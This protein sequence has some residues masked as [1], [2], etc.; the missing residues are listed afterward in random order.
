V[1]RIAPATGA[2]EVLARSVSQD[3]DTAY[4]ARPRSI[5]FPTDQADEGVRAAFSTD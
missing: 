3:V 1:A 4:V 2:V 5:E